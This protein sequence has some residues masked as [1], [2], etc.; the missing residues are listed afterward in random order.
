MLALD[1]Y[2][3]A[4]Q[5]L[6]FVA[7]WLLLKRLWFVPALHVLK[8]RT[9]R[10]EGA[11]E[12]ARKVQGEVERLRREHQAA[13]ERAKSE[14]Q[15]EVAEI[16]RRAQADQKQLIERA[17]E[18]A[19]RTLAEVRTRVAEEVAAARRSLSGE[20]GAIARGGAR[21]VIGR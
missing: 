4:V 12:T 14:A 5:V 15:R 19:Q 13:L 11:I 9:R 3:L 20:G 17:N 18:D 2:S 10:S 16:L 7:L 21:A 1:F 8:E 6:I